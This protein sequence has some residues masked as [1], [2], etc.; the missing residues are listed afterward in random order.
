MS[1][2]T[3][4]AF[5]GTTIPNVLVTVEPITPYVNELLKGIT[6]AKSLLKAGQDPHHAALS[7]SQALAL[8]EANVIIMPAAA[9]SPG[10]A[11]L[12]DKK[13][14]KG[15]IVIELVKLN[16]ADALS[17]PKENPWLTALKE[18]KEEAHDHEHEHEA[19]GTDP[20]VWLDPLRMAAIAPEV[21]NSIARAAPDH[22]AS[23]TRNA[24]VLARHLTTTVHPQLTA[25]LANRTAKPRFENK[26]YLPF[27]TY[28]AAYQY[29]VQRYGLDSGG[30]IT[31][32]PGSMG[33]KSLHHALS[34]AEQLSL[35]CIISESEGA[36][37][38]RIAKRTGARTVILNPERSYSAT[39]TD[40]QPWIMNDY[41]R[42]LYTTAKRFGACL[43]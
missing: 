41:D 6:H 33:A 1:C 13:K 30:F 29:F 22:S 9:M 12:I 14:A 11:R 37:V 43:N 8:K 20:H 18:E 28:H 32:Q 42:L 24:T 36:V 38:Q 23:L 25:L 21:A 17:Y 19:I 2:F 7:P 16:G 4:A 35:G 5:A 31:Q 40:T 26:T 27:I 39:E 10:L 34:S 3:Q 15:T